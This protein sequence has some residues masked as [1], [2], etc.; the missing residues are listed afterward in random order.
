ME[1]RKENGQ[2]EQEW[3]TK[4]GRLV[5]YKEAVKCSVEKHSELL[6][7]MHSNTR[8]T[9]SLSRRCVSRETGFSSRASKTYLIVTGVK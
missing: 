4:G 7:Q 8:L 9:H 6:K 5:K 1:G 2:R 3:G